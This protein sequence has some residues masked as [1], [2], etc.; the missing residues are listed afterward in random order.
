MTIEYKLEHDSETNTVIVYAT[1]H[2]NSCNSAFVLTSE[3]SMLYL[4]G[5]L[6]I[7][8]NEAALYLDRLNESVSKGEENANQESN[9]IH[10]ATS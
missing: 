9:E 7:F 3:P 5:T 2:K 4:L 10:K 6:Q 8:I 1:N